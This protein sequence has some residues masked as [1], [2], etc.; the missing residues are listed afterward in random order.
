M[1]IGE[2]MRNFVGKILF[3]ILQRLVK[4][5]DFKD[6]WILLYLSAQTKQEYHTGARS[7]IVKQY[8]NLEIEVIVRD[9][10]KPEAFTREELLI[11][12][13]KVRKEEI[14][15]GWTVPEPTE[16]ELDG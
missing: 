1:Q 8:K 11:M 9:T 14:R 10:N 7:G 2:I 3:K 6:R 13:R 16:I 5:P 12:L 4:H 15:T